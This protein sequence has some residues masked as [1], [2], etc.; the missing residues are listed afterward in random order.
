MSDRVASI[1]LATYKHALKNAIETAPNA[2]DPAVL[3]RISVPQ[4][5]FLTD[6]YHSSALKVM[7]MGQETLGVQRRLA[8][9]DQTVPRWFDAFYETSEREFEAFDFGFSMKWTRNPFW[10]AFQEVS[11]TFGLVDRRSVAW[12]NLSKVQL[13]SPVGNSVSI[14]SMSPRDRM[15]VVRW[16][17]ALA[18]AELAYAQ[19]D[20]VI[21]FTGGLSWMARCMF[22]QSDGTKEQAAGLR[23]LPDL[24]WSTAELFAPELSGMIAVQTYHPAVWQNIRPKADAERAKMLEWAKKRLAA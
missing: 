18:K 22:G 9:I 19:P 21:M 1:D 20:V 16:Q 4:A 8:E 12:S 13:M 23:Q 15:Q 17:A 5:V 10:T 7:V 11:D 2:L 14:K 3:E 6:A 24:P